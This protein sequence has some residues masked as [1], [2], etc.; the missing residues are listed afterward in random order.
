VKIRRK[1]TKK[2]APY[3][4]L[5]PGKGKAPSILPF[6]LTITINLR[7]LLLSSAARLLFFSAPLLS[8]AYAPTIRVRKSTPGAA[9]G[10]PGFER[11]FSDL[12]QV[13]SGAG[14]GVQAINCRLSR[15]FR[16]RAVRFRCWS[17]ISRCPQGI[18]GIGQGVQVLLKEIHVLKMHFRSR[19]GRLRCRPSNFRYRADNFRRLRNRADYSRCRAGKYRYRARKI[20]GIGQGIF[21]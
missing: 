14:L 1:K 5:L 6:L 10:I 17:F 3:Q 16:C 20:P 12:G 7:A 21:S 19:S 8:P 4:L 11:G 18:S 9:K 15:N 13:I 2:N